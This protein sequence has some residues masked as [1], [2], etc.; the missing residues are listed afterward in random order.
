M[1]EPAVHCLIKSLANCHIKLSKHYKY[2]AAHPEDQLLK[3]ED[4]VVTSHVT[5]EN[6]VMEIFEGNVTG[7]SAT[8]SGAESVIASQDGCW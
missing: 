2:N 8:L 3:A 1:T 5:D 4:I 6:P 7:V